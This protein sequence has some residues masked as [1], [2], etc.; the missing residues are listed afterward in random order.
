MGYYYRDGRYGLPQDHGKAI[1]LWLRA[2]QL[3]RASA[4]GNIAY[5]YIC[6]QG[7]ERDMNKAK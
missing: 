4:Y 5:P 1:E 3:G 6:E 7:V 2:G